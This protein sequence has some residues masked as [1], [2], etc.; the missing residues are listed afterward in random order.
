M[1]AL[2]IFL[3]GLNVLPGLPLDGGNMLRAAAWGITGDDE[4]ASRIA[5]AVGR[6]VGALL[7]GFALW[8]ATRNDLGGAIWF[9]F[10]G[11]IMIQSARLAVS[12]QKL[13]QALARGTAEQAMVAPPPSVPAD[14][15]LSEALDRFLRAHEGEAFPVVEA[16]KLIGMVSFGSA[17]QMGQHDPLRPVREGMIPLEDVE[18]VPADQSLDE[19]ADRLGSQGVALVLRDGTLLGAITPGAISRWAKTHAAT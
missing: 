7:V 8:Q 15:T 13:R 16:G 14:M 6:I 11:M 17:R 18:V 10:I 2:S 5:A 12:R 3:A 4:R 1:G 9:G 19:V